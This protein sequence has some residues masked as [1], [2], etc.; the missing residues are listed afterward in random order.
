MTW[1]DNIKR[2]AR[3]CWLREEDAQDGVKW[4]RMTRINGNSSPSQG[5]NNAV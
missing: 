1:K 5:G 3:K 2:E 4:R